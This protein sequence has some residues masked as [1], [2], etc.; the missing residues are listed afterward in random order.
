MPSD[1]ML[2]ALLPNRRPVAGSRPTRSPPGPTAQ[3]RPSPT[4]TPNGVFT[5]WIAVCLTTP[6]RGAIRVSVSAPELATKTPPRPAA[7]SIGERPT[8]RPAGFPAGCDGPPPEPEPT[9][10]T[11]A[12]TPRAAAPRAAAMR[13]P[14]RREGA[15]RGAGSATGASGAA[16]DTS[17]AAGEGTVPRATISGP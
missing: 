7:T 1:W 9:T 15:A 14:R 8:G 11:T 17:D 2:S 5:A 6:R 4:A 13:A 3:T 16:G 10:R 12:G